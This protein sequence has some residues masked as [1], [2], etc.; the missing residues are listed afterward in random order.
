MRLSIL[1]PVYNGEAY[2]ERSITSILE[3]SLGPEEFEILILDDGSTDDTYTM[4]CD[5][6]ES[7]PQIKVFR[8]H[9]Q[10]LYASRNT[11][12]QKASG[13]FI[14]NLDVDDILVNGQLTRLL[15][16]AENQNFDLLGFRSKETKGSP[17]LSI[18]SDVTEKDIFFGTG[19]EYILSY[20]SHRVEVWWYIVRKDFLKRFG[21]EFEDN[22][23]NADVM[24]TYQVLLH[25]SRMCYVDDIGHLYFQS[26]DSIMRTKDTRRKR[27]LIDTL[28][29]MTISVGNFLDDDVL[30]V[31]PQVL[32]LIKR[33][34]SHFI[35]GNLMSMIRM[36]ISWGKINEKLIELRQL[37]MYPIDFG[38][39]RRPM[40]K[41]RLLSLIANCSFCVGIG[42]LSYRF[43]NL[44]HR[45]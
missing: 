1:I 7:C 4:A 45:S 10:G 8:Q 32:A 24:F 41:Y 40:V 17:E 16:F 26:G 36:G 6:A 20:P 30:K 27:D 29:A 33:V 9:N 39:S 13:T 12:L 35:F 23:Y 5:L 31:K 22:P 3:Q 19:E 42:A 37:G 14:Y 44:F 28:H 34:M 11:L 43:L 21:I 18:N 2:L 38:K 25:C 15:K